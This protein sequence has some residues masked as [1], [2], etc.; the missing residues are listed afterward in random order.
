LPA[1]K[2]YGFRAEA[3][4]YISVSQNEDFTNLDEYRE[5]TRILELTPIKVGETIQL[6]NIFFV[7]S[8]AEILPD[9]EPELERLLKLMNENPRL[10]IELSGHTD[11]RGSASANIKLS[12]ER[13]LAIVNYLI[14]NGIDK[15]RLE[16][17]GYGGTRPIASN[18][19]EVSRSKNRRVEIKVLKI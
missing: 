1:G 2:K 8:K 5:I 10:E 16:F 17:K 11:N 12:E 15:Q 14:E 18:A 19:N 13:A 7:Q 3:E 6:N 9:S 4:G